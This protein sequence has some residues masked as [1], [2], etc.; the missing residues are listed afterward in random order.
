[1]ALTL[2]PAS[3]PKSARG[4][5]SSFA[6]EELEEWAKALKDKARFPQGVTDESKFPTQAAARGR[7]MALRR[8]LVEGKFFDTKTVRS[9]VWPTDPKSEGRKA[10]PKEEH[11]FA[12]YLK[13]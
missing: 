3:P 7:A 13:S 2:K 11:T 6:H 9:R 4:R 10:N 8:A 12:L 5:S 1:M